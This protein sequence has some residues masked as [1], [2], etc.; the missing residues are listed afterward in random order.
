MNSVSVTDITALGSRAKLADVI[1]LLNPAG[2]KRSAEDQEKEKNTLLPS[3][4]LGPRWSNRSCTPHQEA[5]GLLQQSHRNSTVLLQPGSRHSPV[6]PGEQAPPARLD[7]PVQGVQQGQTRGL[8]LRNRSLDQGGGGGVHGLRQGPVQLAK[9]GPEVQVPDL[10]EKEGH[11][12][13]SVQGRIG[14][15]P[16]RLCGKR[17]IQLQGLGSVKLACTLPKGIVHEA[18]IKRENGRWLLSVQ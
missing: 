5:G 10:Q 14:H 2:T 15:E 3:K 7:G 11:R 17:S 8:P 1:S 6:L 18:R 9:P 13:Q 12:N 4:G 16:H